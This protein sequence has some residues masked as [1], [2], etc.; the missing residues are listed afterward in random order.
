[1][2]TIEAR[3]RRELKELRAHIQHLKKAASGG[4]KQAKKESQ[5]E[6]ARL[7][8]EMSDRHSQELTT[9][10]SPPAAITPTPAGQGEE[11]VEPGKKL[12]KQQARKIKRKAQLDQMI[13]EARAEAKDMPDLR[14]QEDT[15]IDAI[16]QT[17]DKRIHPIPA[18]GHCMYNAVA[19]QLQLQQ[20]QEPPRSY[21]DIRQMVAKEMRANPDDY[22]AFV[23]TADG[24]FDAY[25]QSVETEAEWGGHVELQAI[26]RC[27]HRPIVVIQSQLPVLRVEP[28]S[29]PAESTQEIHLSY[30]RHAYG[31]GEHYNSVI[32]SSSSFAAS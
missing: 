12:S 32:P 30:H 2:E 11:H 7:E 25:C 28:R 20:P 3:H 6:I 5:L 18:D 4:N 22:Q 16:L 19:H 31:L 26:A 17:M 21:R 23:D 9:S 15:A 27:I 8:R 24:D 14:A 10:T 29:P 1:M 13:E